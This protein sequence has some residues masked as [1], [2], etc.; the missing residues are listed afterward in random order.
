MVKYRGDRDPVVGEPEVDAGVESDCE[1]DSSEVADGIPG[2]REGGETALP[3]AVLTIGSFSAYEYSRPSIL[4]IWLKLQ[5]PQV[6]ISILLLLHKRDLVR[7]PQISRSRFSQGLHPQKDSGDGSPALLP[8][9]YIRPGK[10]GAAASD[11][12]FL[13]ILKQTLTV[14]NWTTQ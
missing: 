13:T 14:G 3:R 4:S 7:S 12:E 1:G 8:K 6:E 5:I 11:G 9:E 2:M 10:S